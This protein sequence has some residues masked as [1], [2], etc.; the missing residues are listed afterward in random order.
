MGEIN[1][2]CGGSSGYKLELLFLAEYRC[3]NGLLGI[4]YP[5]FMRWLNNGGKS[6]RKLNGKHCVAVATF[7]LFLKETI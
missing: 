4:N 2:S 7:L 5:Q 3:Q 6:G 1:L